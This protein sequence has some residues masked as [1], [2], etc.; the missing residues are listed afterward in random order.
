MPKPRKLRSFL[1]RKTEK[2]RNENPQFVGMKTLNLANKMARAARK[3]L[4]IKGKSAFLG[5]F[6]SFFRCQTEK[7]CILNGCRVFLV[8]SMVFRCS[9]YCAYAQDFE[10][11]RNIFT[12][13]TANKTANFISFFAH[14]K[15]TTESKG[16]PGLTFRL[17]CLFL[18]RK[19]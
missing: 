13:K 7:P 14:K 6:E 4:K 19:A 9:K 8:F 17:L 12:P 2:K 3:S 11:L 1:Q 10:L 5:L 18:C 16:F 15:K